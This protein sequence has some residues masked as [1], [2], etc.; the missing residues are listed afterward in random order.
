[1]EG[2]VRRKILFSSICAICH[3]NGFAYAERP[4]VETLLE[5]LQSLICE[6]GRTSRQYCEHGGRTEPNVA[7]IDI[8]LVCLGIRSDGI[9]D[10]AKRSERI[11]LPPPGKAPSQPMPKILQAG[12][13][14]PLP[15]YIPDYFPS[16][17]GNHRFFESCCEKIP[18][19]LIIFTREIIF[20]LSYFYQFGFRL[21]VLVIHRLNY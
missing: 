13:K 7:D 20:T 17:P 4:A 1:M 15:P 11:V 18:I 3:E 16:F 10:Y 14:K 19:V 6:I 2:S 5:M 12:D 21:I 8:A 9:P